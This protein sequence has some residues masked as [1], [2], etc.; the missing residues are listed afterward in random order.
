[1]IKVAVLLSFFIL[2]TLSYNVDQE[3]TT[4]SGISSGGYMAVQYHVAY[5]G[6][7]KG[8]GVFAGGPYYCAEGQLTNALTRCMY[9]IGIDANRL[10]TLTKDFSNKLLVDNVANITGSKVYLFSGSADTV[11][12]P[13]CM[14]AA[15]TY[16]KALGADIK[17]EF[18]LRSEHALPTTDFGNACTFRGAPYINKC[19]YDG[20]GETLKHAYGT[21]NPRGTAKS[22]N[23]KTVDQVRFIPSG[24]T[25]T[26]LS[27][28]ARAYAYV[29]DSCASGSKCKVHISFHGCLQTIADISDKYY[30][31][32]GFNEWAETNNIIV[33]YPQAAKSSFFSTNPNGCWDWWGYASS[34]YAHNSGPQMLMVKAMAESLTSNYY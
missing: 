15:E 27:V 18:T 21:L 32:S 26:T 5:S 13:A 19:Q 23:I 28:G 17:T 1:V 4:V 25:T 30:T 33:L 34:N 2:Y 11:V 6:A 29:P 14:K 3:G 31:H 8:A 22:G 7:I 9:A 16:Y 12:Y 10:V 20:A 24:W